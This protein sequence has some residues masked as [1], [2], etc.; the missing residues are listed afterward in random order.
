MKKYLYY[1][2]IL[3]GIIHFFVLHYYGIAFFTSTIF[4]Y[5][6]IFL[7]IKRSLNIRQENT[8]TVL[9][10][11][12]KFIMIICLILEFSTTYI[13]K[14]TNTYSENEK[15]LYLSPYKYQ[16]QLELLHFLGNKEVK[17]SWQNGHLP[18][19][20]TKNSSQEF[21]YHIKMNQLGLRGKLPKL[22][23]DPYE[24]RIL[25]LG[26]SF[27]EGFGVEHDTSIFTY[28]LEKK[29][30]FVYANTTVVNGGICGSNPFYEIDLYRNKLKEFNPDL[31]LMSINIGDITDMEYI[32]NR[33]RMPMSE[34]LNAVSHLF[35][36]INGM[37]FRN[38][39]I[40]E[41]TAESLIKKREIIVKN[42]VQLLIKF[43][44][45]LKAENKKFVIIYI[46]FSK[47]FISDMNQPT[48]FL[49]QSIIRS[50]LQVIDLK[51]LYSKYIKDNHKLIRDYY[52]QKDGHHN[53]KGYNLAADI[54]K[55]NLINDSLLFRRQ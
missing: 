6:S 48:D 18:F 23:K 40:N 36:I 1:L 51:F 37:L 41:K 11:N 7:L 52:W 14:L 32:Y 9:L 47:E 4:L 43:N 53:A 20:E 21:N 13:F 54:V 31:V 33:Q 30:Q 27:M 19:E 34:Y 39:L 5:Y 8:S 2:F 45:E 55:T 22:Q 24:F 15:G 12:I 17:N 28:L 29:L 38:D 26:D 49:H 46:P 42:I 44:N 16:R 50:S 25:T 3:L 10:F 35:R